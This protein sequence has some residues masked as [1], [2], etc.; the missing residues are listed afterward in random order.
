MLPHWIDSMFAD[1]SK[2]KSDVISPKVD[3]V[4]LIVQIPYSAILSTFSRSLKNLS[5]T[6]DASFSFFL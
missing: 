1:G 4:A 3:I 6:F 5:I 2:T